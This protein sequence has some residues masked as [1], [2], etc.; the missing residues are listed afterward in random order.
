MKYRNAKANADGSFNCEIEHPGYGWI[1]FTA[2]REDKGALFD[3]GG[4]IDAIEADPSATPYTPPT[5]EE[6]AAEEARRAEYMRA[7]FSM[8][9]AQL[10]IGLV[11]EGWITE[12]EG[13]A[14][15]NRQLPAAVND[16]IA[17][18]PKAQ[19]FAARTKA[20]LP[21]VVL[22]ND[23]LVVALAAQQGKTPEQL[24]DFFRK[25]ADV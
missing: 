13:D 18:L 17:G 6:V 11:A 1:P 21:S 2:R 24:D 22:R 12:A 20:K 14:W 10:L 16:L 8:S 4:L 15:T 9:F 3:V 25:Y 7:S 19:R 23:A 5:A